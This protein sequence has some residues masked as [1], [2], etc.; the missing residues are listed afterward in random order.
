MLAAE[1]R[2]SPRLLT[3]TTDDIQ[4]DNPV[5]LSPSESSPPYCGKRA[6]LPLSSFTVESHPPDLTCRQLELQ[7]TPPTQDIPMD[8]LYFELETANTVPVEL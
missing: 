1:P 8:A 4:G 3:Y 7:D 6:S 2:L 5:P